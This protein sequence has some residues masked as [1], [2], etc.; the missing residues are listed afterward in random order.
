[1]KSIIKIFLI[2]KFIINLYNFL[3]LLYYLF[4][5]SGLGVVNV[6]GF[7]LFPNPAHNINAVLIFI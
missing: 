5:I 7:N 1:M 6:K 3:T 4:L 2:P